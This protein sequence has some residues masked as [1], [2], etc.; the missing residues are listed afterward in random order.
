MHYGVELIKARWL[1]HRREANPAFRLTTSPARWNF[2]L[3][4]PGRDLKSVYINT[5]GSK[6]RGIY[7]DISVAEIPGN[8]VDNCSLSEALRRLVR[9]QIAHE[10]AKKVRMRLINYNIYAYDDPIDDRSRLEPAP[11]QRVNPR[12]PVLRIT[13]HPINPTTP[14]NLDPNGSG[15]ATTPLPSGLTSL[16]N[17]GSRASGDILRDKNDTLE[18]ATS[19]KELPLPLYTVIE[20]AQSQVVAP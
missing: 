5:D 3:F 16:P 7:E 10:E 20:V 13:H 2:V 18:P 11:P 14:S 1:W 4:L 19:A 15:T 17:R 6:Y 9:R 12:V 8:K